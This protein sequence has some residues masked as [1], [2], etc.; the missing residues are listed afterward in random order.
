MSNR[1]QWRDLGALVNEQLPGPETMSPNPDLIR[2]V[3]G[4][5][6]I[7]EHDAGRAFN[8]FMWGTGCPP[9]PAPPV[10]KV[11]RQPGRA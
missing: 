5:L 2:R 11:R 10:R 3:A 1:K 8:V 9:R 6:G 4:Q 7:P